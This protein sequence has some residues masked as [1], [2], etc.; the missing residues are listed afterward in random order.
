MNI[1]LGVG[2]RRS[3]TGLGEKKLRNEGSENGFLLAELY[4]PDD[5]PFF[6][7]AGIVHFGVCASASDDTGP[8]EK[9][10]D[11]QCSGGNA[12]AFEE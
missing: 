6:R 8:E 4:G 2:C 5:E 11:H 10:G 7:Y 9:A 3:F 1:V 12:A